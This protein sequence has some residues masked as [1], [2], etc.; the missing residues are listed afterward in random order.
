M[1]R[2]SYRLVCAESCCSTWWRWGVHM[3]IEMESPAFKSKVRNGLRFIL[4]KAWT[5]FP[6][7]KKVP[8]LSASHHPYSPSFF[9][10]GGYAYIKIIVYWDSQLIIVNYMK[11]HGTRKNKTKWRLVT[12][13]CGSYWLIS[14]WKSLIC[15]KS[16]NQLIFNHQAHKRRECNHRDDF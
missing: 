4:R 2:I 7:K 12:T 3:L 13:S 16:R 9:F 1:L 8:C 15:G 11:G 5:L 14:K 10:F 6:A